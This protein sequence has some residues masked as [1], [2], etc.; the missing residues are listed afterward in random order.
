MTPGRTQQGTGSRWHEG[1]PGDI[2]VLGRW[3]RKLGCRLLPAQAPR[4]AALIL[5]LKVI[6]LLNEELGFFGRDV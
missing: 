6:F 1:L 2:A 5:R 3:R 4:C